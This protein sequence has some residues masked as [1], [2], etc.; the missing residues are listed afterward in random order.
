MLWKVHC[1]SQWSV[2]T[3]F[4]FYKFDV[5][6]AMLRYPNKR[7]LQVKAFN[8]WLAKR[9]LHHCKYFSW[10]A[11]SVCR[12]ACSLQCR[13]CCSSMIYWSA[14][15]VFITSLIFCTAPNYPLRM[16][17]SLQRHPAQDDFT[18]WRIL[19]ISQLKPLLGCHW[20]AINPWCDQ[21]SWEISLVTNDTLAP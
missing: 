3:L 19:L 6:Q 11:W 10:R 1:D 12:R 17:Y 13:P 20:S 16:I 2:V 7:E 9:S 4:H 21:K 5:L 14:V 15:T 8:W 18:V